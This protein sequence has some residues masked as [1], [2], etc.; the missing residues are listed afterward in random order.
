MSY[1]IGQVVRTST[2]KTGVIEG[3]EYWDL[4][5]IRFSHPKD[6]ALWGKA[7]YIPYKVRLKGSV[8]SISHKNL[9]PVERIGLS[10]NVESFK[11]IAG[12]LDSTGIQYNF[13]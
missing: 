11:Q 6:A 13:I 4:N 10:L 3:V 1:Q 12:L 8:V 9:T 7:T 5:G 2:G